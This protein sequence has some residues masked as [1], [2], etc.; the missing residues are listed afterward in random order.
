MLHLTANTVNE[1]VCT[2]SEL[3][4]SPGTNDVLFEFQDA[5]TY[6]K[7]YCVTTGNT[8]PSP[9]RYDVF[10]INVTSSPDGTNAEV[11]L[12]NNGDYIYTCYE[13]RSSDDF[14]DFNTNDLRQVETGYALISGNDSVSSVYL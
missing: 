2:C 12:P 8:S 11:N 10:N 4:L 14:N 6:E 3:M 9:G 5:R 7:Y 13:W 1:L